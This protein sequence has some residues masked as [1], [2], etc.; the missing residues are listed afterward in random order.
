MTRRLRYAHAHLRHLFRY[1]P[2]Q[3][4]HNKRLRNAT[5]LIVAVIRVLAADTGLWTDDVRVVDSTP[6]QCSRSRET[7]KRSEL[8]GWAEYGCCALPARRTRT[9]GTALFKPLRQTVESISQTLEAQLDL[10]RHGGRTPAGVIAR[11]LVLT[12]AIWHNDHTGA[13]I[14]RSPTAY[15]H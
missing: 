4:G 3:P 2:K 12:A 9:P 1:L 8:A 10:E 6:V 13:P 5:A 15:D 11:I 14:H 7:V